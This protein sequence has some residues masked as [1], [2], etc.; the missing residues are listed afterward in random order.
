M[1]DAE[2]QGWRRTA[3]ELVERALEELESTGGHLKTAI[4]EHPGTVV[5]PKVFFLFHQK[6][7]SDPDSFA[8]Y[9]PRF[10]WVDG[11]PEPGTIHYG[12]FKGCSSWGWDT[13][14]ASHNI[15]RALV[16]PRE[17]L[18]LVRRIE[19]ATRWAEARIAG[20]ERAEEELARQQSG[21]IDTLECELAMRQLAGR[22]AP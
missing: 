5:R 11:R 22:D 10:E 4:H 9:W 19:A 3:A 16:S 15:A 18:A 2:L 20:I 14:K 1:P 7:R 17:G 13:K 21:V 12:D 8:F 6:D